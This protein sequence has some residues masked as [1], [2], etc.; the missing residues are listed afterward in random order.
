MEGKFLAARH[1]LEDVT[2]GGVGREQTRHQLGFRTFAP[3][4]SDGLPKKRQG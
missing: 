4:G 2:A 1:V 3:N